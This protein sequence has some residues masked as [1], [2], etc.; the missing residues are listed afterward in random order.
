MNKEER[1]QH[2]L[3]TLP[4]WKVDVKIKY[5]RRM[6]RPGRRRRLFLPLLQ[7]PLS[8]PTSWTAYD[9]DESWVHVEALD[10]KSARVKAVKKVKENK[11][12]VRIRTM[13]VKRI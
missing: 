4:K 11:T 10:E 6:R 13:N 9:C 1:I 7:V 5:G 3:G 12:N 8:F 2:A